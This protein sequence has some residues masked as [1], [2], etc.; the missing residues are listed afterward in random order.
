M[1]AGL[2]VVFDTITE[3]KPWSFSVIQQGR[4]CM[5]ALRVHQD[6]QGKIK[7]NK[8]SGFLSEAKLC[9]EQKHALISLIS[10]AKMKFRSVSASLKN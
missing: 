9:I 7:H 1:S 2:K 5:A 4:P 3:T 8:I 10:F 6:L